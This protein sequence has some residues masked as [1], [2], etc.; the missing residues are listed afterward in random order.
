MM[1]KEQAET[2]SE[3]KTHYFKQWYLTHNYRSLTNTP[4]IPMVER[5]KAKACGLS[6]AG[7]AS[8]NPAA[9]TDVS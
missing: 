3:Y 6:L 5:S 7:V 9:G 2:C 1:A 8:S 4:P